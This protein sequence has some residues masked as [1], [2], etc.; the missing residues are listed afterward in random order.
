MRRKKLLAGVLTAALL[1]GSISPAGVMG[2]EVPEQLEMEQLMMFDETEL[3]KEEEEAVT[4]GA[5]VNGFVIEDGVLTDYVGEGGDVTIPVGVT[6]IGDKAFEECRS[7][8]SI[9]IPDSVTSIGECAF[10]NCNSLTSITIPKNADF[11]VLHFISMIFYGCSNLKEIEV[12]KDNANYTSDNG[13]LYDKG[14]KKLICCPEG[15]VGEVAIPTSVTEIGLE[16]VRN[17]NAL[18]SIALPAS[19]TVIRDMYFNTCSSLKEIKVDVD[20]ANYASENG[21]LYDKQKSTLLCCPGGKGGEVTLPASVTEI[22][23]YAFSGCNA[24][25]SIMLP[26]SVTNI[27][28]CAFRRCSNLTSITIPDSV[29]NI[30]E[31]AF[32]NCSKDLIIYCVENSYAETYAKENHIKYSY[33]GGKAA[34]TITA[35]DN[36]TKTFGDSAFSIG[37]ATNGD[38]TLS[39]VSDNET[40]AKVDSDGK[41]TLIRAGI[42]HVT[43]T[44]TETD[45][46]KAAEKVITITVAKKAQTITAS[47]ITKTL[48]DAT[49]SLNAAVDGDGTLTYVSDNPSIAAITENRTV[50]LVGAG[51]AHIT[52]TAAETAN[53][54]AAERVITITVG[55]KAQTITAKDITKTYGDKAFSLG[56]KTNGGGKLTYKILNTQIAMIDKKGKI[57]IKGCGRTQIKITAAANENYQKATKTLTLTVKPEKLTLTSVKSTK[58]KALTVKWKQDKKAKGYIIEYS[59]DKKFKKSVKTVTISKN[60]TVSKTVT[61]LKGGKTYYVRACAYTTAGGK[62]IK[63]NYSKVKSV[64]VKK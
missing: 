63:G 43:I 29:T 52:I 16:A 50:T 19:V 61:K 15:K 34:Q 22:R 57:T 31:D 48:G 53:Y 11:D 23:S 41:V 12:D 17:C 4:A 36:I 64:K 18:T 62:K 13:I 5:D 38:G 30:Q 26:D 8:T 49:F 10:M 59:T 32:Y 28:E 55:K 33:I 39:Y 60:S 42:A 14:K 54:K 21:I 37:A 47:D 7:I 27:G 20:N 46:Y 9:T 6:S 58:S 56:A 2:A 45:T 40:V 1:V 44:A 24:L 3:Q 35:S 51:T 25:T